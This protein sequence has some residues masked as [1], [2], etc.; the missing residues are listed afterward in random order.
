[1]GLTESLKRAREGEAS[2][3][4]EG[5][6]LQESARFAVARVKVGANGESGRRM[7]VI[8]TV[9]ENNILYR[10]HWDALHA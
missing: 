6:V 7:T 8:Y 4:R 2:Y 3:F 9:Y 10:E 5:A 1:M